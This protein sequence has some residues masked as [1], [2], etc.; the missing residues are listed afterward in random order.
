VEVD[1][2][3]VV[4]GWTDDV[5]VGEADGCRPGS[6]AVT[7]RVTTRPRTFMSPRLIG[8]IMREELA[9]AYCLQGEKFLTPGPC[10]LDF[11]DR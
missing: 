4:A 8:T 1:V 6:Q 9:S 10:R 7:R 5:E 2:V 11:L 3:A